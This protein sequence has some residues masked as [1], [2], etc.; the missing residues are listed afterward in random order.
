[1]NAK[2]SEPGSTDRLEV[3]LSHDDAMVLCVA[4]VGPQGCDL[5]APIHR[6]AAQWLAMLGERHFRLTEQLTARGETLDVAGARVWGAMEAAMKAFDARSVRLELQD[7]DG[8]AAVFRVSDGVRSLRVLTFPKRLSRGERMVAVVTRP[9]ER[10]DELEKAATEEGSGA[11]SSPRGECWSEWLSTGGDPAEFY[12]LR[13]KLDGPQADRRIEFRFPL[14]FKDAANVDRTLYFVRFFEWMGRLREMALRPVLARLTSEFA[15][16]ERAWVT[17]RSWAFIEGPVV[18][19][20]VMEVSCRFLERSGPGDATV[21]VGFD[22]H[23]VRENGSL[24]RVAMTQ[25]QVTWTRVLGHGVV[26]PEPH[27]PFL[28]RFFREFMPARRA[29]VEDGRRRHADALALVGVAVWQTPPGPASGMLL[30]EQT[31][32]TSIGDANLVGNVYYSKYYELQG[33]LRDGYFF[34]IVP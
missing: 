26:A 13:L 14:G 31:C 4:G 34:G 33:A 3:S 12:R 7:L 2:R 11:R 8:D 25:I 6:D 22:W 16:G 27:P 1:M 30:V 21:D 17:N 19:G 18:G 20:E 9:I 23:R 15:S 24:E 29:P 5:V 28:D 32:V 10:V